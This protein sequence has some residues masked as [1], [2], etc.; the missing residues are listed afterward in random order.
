[1]EPLPDPLNDRVMKDSEPPPAKPLREDLLFPKGLDGPPDWRCLQAH[2]FREGRVKKEHCLHLIR[3]VAAITSCEPNLL[4]LQDPITVVGDI[5]GQFY[6]LV[7]LLEVGGAVDKTQYLF[8]GDYVDR[9]SFSV[10][11]VLTL[12]AIKLCYPQ[13]IWMLRGNHECRQMTA[14][15]NF[16]DECET[17]PRACMRV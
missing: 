15:F 6:D 7:K 10:E 17:P 12:F 1:M 8:L 16:R 11:V 2:F 3:R 5:H 4:R 14:F 13:R 9:G